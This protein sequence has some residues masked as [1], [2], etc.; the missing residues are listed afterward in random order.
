MTPC[1][2]VVIMFSFIELNSTDDDDVRPSNF[3]ET[4]QRNIEWVI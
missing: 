3:Q 1:V 2:V 4:T